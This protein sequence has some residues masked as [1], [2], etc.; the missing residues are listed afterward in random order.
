MNPED[1]LNKTKSESPIS[2]QP[3]ETNDT[4]Q[5]FISNETSS[6]EKPIPAKSL[7][8]LESTFEP[9]SIEPLS[10]SLSDLTCLFDDLEFTETTRAL[11][12]PVPF[13]EIKPF[14]FTFMNVNY[15]VDPD[16]PII[17]IVTN[18]SRNESMILDKILKTESDE[19]ES[20]TPLLRATS[21]TAINETQSVVN[22][23]PENISQDTTDIEKDTV[24]MAAHQNVVEEVIDREELIGN[25]KLLLEQRE[26]LKSK[27]SFLQNRLGEYFK[28]KRSDENRDGEKSVADQEQRYANCMAA[29]NELRTE[30]ETLN[31][32]NAKVVSEYKSKLED[33]LSE[34]T[35]K[36]TEFTKF[37]RTTAVTAENSR[38]GKL[39]P[40]KVIEQLETT[41][42][43]K[44]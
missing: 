17:S 41:E 29:L 40:A 38:T 33:R 23:M 15:E 22:E 28:R 21:P 37:K 12:S 6:H 8:M 26:K 19:Y 18:L 39:I 3:P 1:V 2:A 14:E 31:T 11:I 34:A 42:Q 16:A 13:D 43:R 4:E 27:N 7:T 36:A 35:N 5:P 24:S 20:T 9:E 44:E 32:T 30:Y 25:I 10:E